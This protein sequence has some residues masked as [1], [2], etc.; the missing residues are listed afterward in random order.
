MKVKALSRLLIIVTIL[1]AVNPG[2]SVLAVVDLLYFIAT[3]GNVSVVL[4]WETAT[5]F[6]NIGFYVRRGSTS[7]GPFTRISPL[8]ISIGDPLTGHLYNFED[9][10]VEIGVLYY[11]VLEVL[12]ADGTSNLTIPVSAI[13]PGPTAT[14]T[15]TATQTATPVVSPSPTTTNT[16]PL[17][18]APAST[19]TLSYTA[20]P[21]TTL[22]LFSSTGINFPVWN[23]TRIKTPEAVAIVEVATEVVKIDDTAVAG[24]R[25]R[26][27]PMV[28]IAILLWVT[29][30]LFIFFIIRFLGREDKNNQ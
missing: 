15:T 26:I 9:T 24:N 29:L 10:S 19:S 17:P 4:T 5:E 3:P 22:E 1:G 27:Q 2:G 23:P 20:T 25:A 12:N 21:T 28:I 18:V 16:P 11:Y 6:D 14:A 7:T 8:I 13:I 30:A